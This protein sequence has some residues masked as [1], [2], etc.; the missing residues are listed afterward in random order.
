MVCERI[1]RLK[2]DMYACVKLNLVLFCLLTGKCAT[3]KLKKTYSNLVYGH[4]VDIFCTYQGAKIKM[5]IL[6]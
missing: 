6:A 5:M 3:Q 4:I 2:L 1:H